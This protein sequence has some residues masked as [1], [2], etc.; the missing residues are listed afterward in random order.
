MDN[1]K[2]MF[3]VAK[4]APTHFAA[5][6]FCVCSLC[7]HVHALTSVMPAAKASTKNAGW[8]CPKCGRE[9]ARRSAYHGCGQYTVEGYLEGKNPIAVF[10]FKTLAQ[11]AQALGPVTI[12]AVKTQITFRMRATFLMVSVSGRQLTGYL[13]L[14]RATPAPFFKK[15]AAASARRHVH[16]FRV[17]DEATITGPFAELLREAI[18]NDTPHAT[19][20][21][22]ARKTTIGEE[23]NALYRADRAQSRQRPALSA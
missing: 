17:T 15:I 6:S 8:K 19:L 2:D 16:V 23:I 1:P 9:F 22:S 5:K 14:P 20:D 13:F 11:T 3:S 18:A 4:F 10:L 21:T 12:V 7:F